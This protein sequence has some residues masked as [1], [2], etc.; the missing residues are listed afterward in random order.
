MFGR[1]FLC[2]AALTVAVQPGP[3]PRSASGNVSSFEKKF[4]EVIPGKVYAGAQP[5]SERD[6]AFL[7]SRGIKTLIN[8]RKYLFWEEGGVHKRATDHG[9]LYRHAAMPTLW[10]TPEESEVE[11]AL[12]AL[13]DLELQ[14]VYVHCMLGRDRT[15]MIVA[16]YRVLY[17]KRDACDAWKEWKTRGYKA[18]NRGLKSYFEKRVRTQTDRPN[19]NPQFSVSQC[20]G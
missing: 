8:L 13:D 5:D 7:K 20:P 18:Y 2:A 6:Y 17:E 4:T 12:S 3:E 14:P 19:F 1:V 10:N 15:G 11:E 9:F 16:L